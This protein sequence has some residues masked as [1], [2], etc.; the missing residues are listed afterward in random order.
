MAQWV[1][2]G[3]LGMQGSN[4]ETKARSLPTVSALSENEFV[5]LG[6]NS[7]LGILNDGFLVNVESCSVN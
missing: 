1:L 6:G 5:V 7:R 2:L 3:N 4:D